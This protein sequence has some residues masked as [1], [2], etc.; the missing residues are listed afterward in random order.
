MHSIKTARAL[1]IRITDAKELLKGSLKPPQLRGASQIVDLNEIPSVFSLQ[2][3]FI[4]Q[5]LSE[6]LAQDFISSR[7]LDPN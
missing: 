6:L 3:P 7:T 5:N 1:S 4:I 2:Q